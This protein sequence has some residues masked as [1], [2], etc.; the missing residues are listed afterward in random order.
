M[1]AESGK[2]KVGKDE[3]SA[4]FSTMGYCVALSWKASRFYTLVRFVGRIAT[5]A[6]GILSAF[7][8][9]YIIDLLAGA[10]VPENGAEAT[11]PVLLGGTLA[12]ALAAAGIRKAIQYCQTMHSELLSRQIT[13]TIMEKALSVDIEFFDNPAYYDKLMAASRDSHSIVNILWNVLEC[14]SSSITFAGAFAVLCGSNPLYGL[15]VLLAAFPSAVAGVRYT[16]SLYK[17]SIEQ[18][19]GERQK[20]YLHSISTTRQHA[21]DIRLFDAGGYLKERYAGIWDRLFGKRRKMLRKRSVLTGILELLPEIAI[22][23]ITVDVCYRVLSGGATIGDY[24]LYTGLAAQLNASVYAL[25]SST[26]QIYDDKLRVANIKTLDEFRNRVENNGEKKLVAVGTIEFCGV[27]FAY[28]GGTRNVLEDVSFKIAD[29]EK[30]ALVGLNGSGKSTLIKLLLRFYDVDNGRVIINGTDIREFELGSLRR[31]FSVYFQDMQNYSFTLRENIRF[32][33][34]DRTDGDAAIHRAFFDSDA[35]DLLDSLP[36]G[37][38][39]YLTRI[40]QDDGAELSGGQSQKVALARAFYRRHS[41]LILDEPSS[42]LDPEAE[43]RVFEGLKQLCE[44][45]TTLFTSHRLSNIVLADRIIVIENG[46]I[47]EQGTQAELL[48]NKSRYAEL[49]RYQQEK[50]MDPLC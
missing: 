11:L 10:W 44:G 50:F 5:P 21:Q 22:L 9:K 42:N 27:T 45:K 20:H 16:K 23:G 15:A 46:R 29:G 18:I 6:F 33:D 7:L 14:M 30:V 47:V 34:R 32:A 1:K 24:S 28:P 31:A 36:H 2:G 17:L 39:T 25:S 48:R 12:L 26:L 13:M 43:H 4:F 19:N 8:V 37:L 3:L 41:A 35:A 38:D 49:F 40:F